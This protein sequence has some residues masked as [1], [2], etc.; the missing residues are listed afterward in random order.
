M[1]KA[2]QLNEILP[3]I[4]TAHGSL[5][6]EGPASLCGPCPKCGGDDRFV[7][8]TESQRFWCRQCYPEDKSGDKIA[9]HMWIEGLDFKGL[10][11]KYLPELEPFE[12]PELGPAVEKYAYTDISGKVLYY[13]CR[14]EPKAFRQCSADGL[15]WSTKDIKPKVPYQLPR[16][17]KTETIFIVEGEKDCHSLEKLNLVGTCNVGGAGNWTPDLNHHFKDKE[18]FMLAD[19]DK[20]GRDHIAKVYENLKDIAASIKQIELSGLQ[21][22]G[23][24]TDWLNGF[25]DMETAAERLAIMVENAEPYEP[26]NQVQQAGGAGL[27]GLKK[28]DSTG[29]SAAELMLMNLPEPKW[30]IPDILPEGLGILAGKPKMGKSGLSLNIGLAVT[31]GGK[32]LGKINVEKGAVLYLALEDTKRR[33]KTRLTAMLQGSPA[34]SNLHIEIAWPKIDDGG[35]VK[36]DKR[37]QE[38][39]D[40]RLVIIDTLKKIRPVQKGR[41][42][43]PYDIDYE[44][45]AAIKALADKH[46]IAI[47]VI[48]HLRKSESEDIMDD[49]SG[50]FGLTGA[51]DSLLAFK[52]KTGQSDAELHLVGRDLDAAEYALKY[53]PDIW[54]WELIGDAQEVK[55]TQS[56]QAV[57]DAIKEADEVLTPKEIE[58]ISGV[59]Y[60]TVIKG[61]KLLSEDGSIVKTKYGKYRIPA[62]L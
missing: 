36:L 7:Y 25:D 44:N 55:S 37:I 56:K 47:L 11:K 42:S 22:G 20:P 34:P 2:T 30:A 45:V 41:N 31:A 52:R 49:F 48:H 5:K 24:F 15:K 6:K 32:A 26:K 29:F 33:L 16:V 9:Y 8:K 38:I 1:D 4:P 61:L 39:P 57:Y 60:W 19:N 59:K 46:G 54:T 23:D 12:H 3:D 18:L 13:N 58:K 62:Y 21:K 28:F 35:L 40:I 27:Y 53:H 51:A 17:I 43:N 50:T 14:F 10:L